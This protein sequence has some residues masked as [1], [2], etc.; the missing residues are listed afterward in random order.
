VAVI[1]YTD[2][3]TSLGRTLTGSEQA[4]VYQWIGDAELLIGARLG[5]IALLDQPTLAYVVREAV[6]SRTRNPD[7]MQSETID[8]Y[9][10]RLPAET[11]RVTILDEWWNLLDPQTGSG[12]FSVRPYF[13][14]D[15]YDMWL[16]WT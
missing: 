6:V 1:D 8:D 2:V 14:A 9:T 16:D 10:Y 4:Q 7:G 3:E 13:E 15:T 5:D 12:A 11:R